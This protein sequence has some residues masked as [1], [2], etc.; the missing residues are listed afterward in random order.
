[1]ANSNY[2]LQSFECAITGNDCTGALVIVWFNNSSQFHTDVVLLYYKP[3][4]ISPNH[5][6]SFRKIKKLWTTYISRSDFSRTCYLFHGARPDS[7]TRFCDDAIC[8]HL[9]YVADSY[10]LHI[11]GMTL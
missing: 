1:M 5:R 6:E 11:A 2:R 8:L 4:R 10:L 9:H 7:E 3:E